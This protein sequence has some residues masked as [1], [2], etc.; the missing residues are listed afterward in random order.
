MGRRFEPSFYRRR[1][2]G[3]CPGALL[4]DPGKLPDHQ[5]GASGRDLLFLRLD[6]RDQALSNLCRAL[7]PLQSDLPGARV[8]HRLADLDV[9]DLFASAPGRKVERNSETRARETHCA[10]KFAADRAG[11][12]KPPSGLIRSAAVARAWSGGMTAIVLVALLAGVVRGQVGN[13]EHRIR[14]AAAEEQSEATADESPTPRPKPKTKKTASP[15][16]HKSPTPKKKKKA[17][18]EE[19]A[20]PTPKKKSSAKKASP[21]PAKKKKGAKPTASAKQEDESEN[22]K[23]AQTPAP[24]QTPV[25][26]AITSPQGAMA[27]PSPAAPPVPGAASSPVETLGEEP[28]ELT[29][30]KTGS[31][32]RP[33]FGIVSFTAAGKAGAAR[34]TVT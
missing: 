3:A 5:A 7:R 21:S 26:R 31:E 32:K 24:S 29:I 10:G 19:D 25:A 33:G 22:A 11:C 15:A 27:V 16:A 23:P 14:I 30:E 4:V 9:P 8:H 28:A 34:V 17:A 20:T 18:E 12:L 1:I 2:G 13:G 6:R